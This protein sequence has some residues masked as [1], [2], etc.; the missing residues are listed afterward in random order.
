[1]QWLTI[2]QMAKLNQVS[3]QTLRLYDREGLLS[4]GMRG[5]D[6]GYRYYNIKQSA[7]LDIIQY[8]KSLGMNLRDIKAQLESGE[9]GYLEGIL[10]Q[11]HSQIDQQIKELKM[12]RRAVERTL[13]SYERYHAAP[14]DGTIVLEYIGKRQMYC[15]DTKYN[16]YDQGIEAYEQI[17]REL[18]S[19]LA[20]DQLPQI[21]YCNAGTILR[22]ENLLAGRFYSTEVFVFVDREYVSEDFITVQPSGNY[23]CIYCDNFYKE[24]EYARKLLEETAICGYTI[25]GDYLCE[26]VAELPLMGSGERG[27]FLKLQI[28]IKFNKG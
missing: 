13:E 21:Y 15:V 4:P 7:V 26:T 18:R 20:Q 16:F 9:S 8:M 17:L 10:Q 5:E 3:E 6:N 27:M 19:R 23:L 11:K 24:K 22:K 28:P 1:M 25:C 2:G 14:P 12:Q